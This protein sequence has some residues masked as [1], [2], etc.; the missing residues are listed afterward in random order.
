M[1]VSLF[2]IYYECINIFL[3]LFFNHYTMLRIWLFIAV[4][5]IILILWQTVYHESFKYFLL[6]HVICLGCQNLTWCQSLLDWYFLRFDIIIVKGYDFFCTSLP[7]TQMALTMIW[8]SLSKCTTLLIRS[9]T[10]EVT[11]NLGSLYGS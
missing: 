2:K 5:D 11:P 9:S 10:P 3:L 7:H 1:K 6:Q 8:I 4:I